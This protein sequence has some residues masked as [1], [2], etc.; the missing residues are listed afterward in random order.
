M[1]GMS[2]RVRAAESRPEREEKLRWGEPPQ[3]RT[4]E[5]EGERES[6]R[7]R[8]LGLSAIN[9]YALAVR[10]SRSLKSATLGRR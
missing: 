6:A 3:Y 2:L 8:T 5:R 4:Q 7:H 9:I 1:P 10:G